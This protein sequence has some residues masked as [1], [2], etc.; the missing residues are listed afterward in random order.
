MYTEGRWRSRSA[1]EHPFFTNVVDYLVHISRRG[2]LEDANNTAKSI[3][4]PNTTATVTK[5]RS[6]LGLCYVFGRLVPS[7][8]RI[9]AS[10]S[11]RLKKTQAKDLGPLHED[12]LQDLDILQEKLISPWVLCL[13]TQNEY[14]ILEKDAC[15]KDVTYVIL[16]S[17]LRWMLDLAEANGKL[18]RCML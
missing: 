6:F 18:V 8:K 11:S 3:H 1:S 14:C 17:A 7:F 16:Q 5:S 10:L 4:E 2:R 9:S 12:K 13:P 15:D